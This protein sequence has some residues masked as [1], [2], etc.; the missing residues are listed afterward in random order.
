MINERMRGSLKMYA[1]VITLIERFPRAY[2]INY[3]KLWATTMSS[4]VKTFHKCRLKLYTVIYNVWFIQFN[5]NSV[6][7]LTLIHFVV[8][9]LGSL[10]HTIYRHM[11]SDVWMFHHY[12]ANYFFVHWCQ[13]N[14]NTI[15]VFFRTIDRIEFT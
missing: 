2:K 10:F 12:L 13:D 9:F 3:F 7:I 5:N 1:L 8:Y 6:V 15:Y 4:I 14:I 11:F